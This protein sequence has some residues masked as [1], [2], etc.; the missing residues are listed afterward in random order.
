LEMAPVAPSM[1]LDQ[2]LDFIDRGGKANEVARDFG[3]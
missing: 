1:D 2:P 3:T